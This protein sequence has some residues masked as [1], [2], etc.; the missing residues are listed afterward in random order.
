V[1]DWRRQLAEVIEDANRVLGPTADLRIELAA[2]APWTPRSAEDD[3]QALLDE[4][5]ASDPGKDVE[6]VV[7]LVGSTPRYETSFRQLGLAKMAAPHFVIRTVNDAREYE[8]VRAMLSE[9]DD[10]ER[11]K[12]HR[13]RKR[14]KTTS[15]FLHELAHTLGVP[16]ELDAATIMGPRYGTKIDGFSA[17]AAQL[18]R[19]YLDHELEPR[20][21]TE[22]AFAKAVLAHLERTAAVW[23]PK[24]REEVVTRVQPLLAEPR[25][26]AETASSTASSTAPVELASLSPTDR[27]TF[28]QATRDMN[29]RPAE[30]WTTAQPLFKA[31]PGVYAVQDLRCQLAMKT[32]MAWE[33]AQ[34][35]CAPLLR[36]V[37]GAAPTPRP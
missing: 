33:S 30:A 35:E 24:D 31:Y 3:L 6:R 34:A 8:S 13:A 36:L 5:I 32:G 10:V 16:H 27:A 15:V 11:A 29:A 25:R 1:L 14:H 4:L 22:Q 23:V 17:P 19:L 9:L 2:A 7:G 21:Q 28:E 18:M 12:V 20:A 26:P 37:P